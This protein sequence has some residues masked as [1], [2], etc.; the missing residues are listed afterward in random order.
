MSHA[1]KT[2]ND[3]MSRLPEEDR[4]VIEAR[5]RELEFLTHRGPIPPRLP[6]P[7]IIGQHGWSSMVLRNGRL[8]IDA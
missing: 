2:L 4:V 6:A 5:L 7:Y 1:V 8:S 3:V